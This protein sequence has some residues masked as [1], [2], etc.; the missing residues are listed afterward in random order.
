MLLS[1]I[2]YALR[3]LRRSLGQTPVIVLTLA[4]AIAAATIV[5]STIDMVWHLLPIANR[6]RLVFVA[7]VDAR[8]GEMMRLGL[9][10]PDLAD[11]S[12]QSNTLEALAGFSLGSASLT[13]V[14]VQH[15]WRSCGLRQIFRQSG[16]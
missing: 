6:D 15:G 5:Y 10:T 7:A 2:R 12:T 1:D 8:R 9:S 11:V 14:D 3:T 4:V 13:G 16:D